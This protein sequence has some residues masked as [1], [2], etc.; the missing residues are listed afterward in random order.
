[1]PR[2]CAPLV[3]LLVIL[4]VAL[5]LSGASAALAPAPESVAGEPV[6]L[7]DGGGDAQSYVAPLASR[8]AAPLSQFEVEYENFP[9]EAEAAVQY[10]IEIWQSVLVS[11]VPIRVS[12]SWES[13]EEGQLGAARATRYLRNFSGAPRADTF[14]PVALA[15][16]LAGDDQ[17]P[18]ESDIIITINSDNADWYYG[19]GAT[20]RR[21]SS[22][23]SVVLHEI[24]HGLGFSGTA[25]VSSSRASWSTS[26]PRI[27]DLYVTTGAGEPL[28][29]D[30]RFPAYSAELR[31]ALLGGDL[32]FAGPQATAAN[33]GEAPLLYAPG[34]WEQ[35]SSFGHLDE[36]TYPAGDPNALMTPYLE[37]G[38]TNYDPGP[39][40]LGI[41]ADLG[42]PLSG[43]TPP[44]QSDS[45]LQLSPAVLDLGDVTVGATGAPQTVTL[46]NAGASALALAQE[47]G[48]G[49]N[50]GG[51]A[52]MAETCTAAPVAPGRSCTVIVAFTP[53]KP[54]PVTLTWQA[55]GANGE[56]L[57]TLTLRAS[58]VEN[59]GMME[60][61]RCA[62]RLGRPCPRVPLDWSATR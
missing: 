27:Y 6:I 9:P 17:R 53:S 24:G 40:A 25:V 36:E 49:P 62:A 59:D 2:F 57:A 46:T 37:R 51:F 35:G 23:V 42:W 61:P 39:V 56:S 47:G 29:D 55:A 13:M 54:G 1:M 4:I 18:G 58:G 30:D 5:S 31:D 34:R 50:G 44:A 12:A 52:T 32:R 21:Q 45:A 43:G 14:Y 26:I 20:P 15:D 60:D 28:R 11:P 3:R 48:F 8:A 19:T 10:A 38:E 33:G 22:L 7:S 41:L 16:A